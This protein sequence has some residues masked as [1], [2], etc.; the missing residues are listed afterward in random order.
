[1]EIFLLILAL[2]PTVLGVAELIHLLRMLVFSPLKKPESYVL[3]ILESD[4]AEEQLKYAILK[5]GWEHNNFKRLIAVPKGIS[6]SELSS[7]RVLAE[8]YG[9]EIKE[10]I[11]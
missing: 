4:L 10:A 2:I 6:E 5:F 7:C 11:F 3:V 1:M 8:E 9:V